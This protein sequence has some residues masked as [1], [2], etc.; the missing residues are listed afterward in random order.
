VEE[1]KQSEENLK[2]KAE[3][4]LE[5]PGLKEKKMKIE[6]PLQLHSFK[7]SSNFSSLYHYS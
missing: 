3:I 4:R 5:D 1:K 6:D 2:R 7:V